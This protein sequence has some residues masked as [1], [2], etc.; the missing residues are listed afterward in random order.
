MKRIK[1]IDF[2]RGFAILAMLFFHSSYYWDS[3][4][5]REQMNQ[6]LS[7]PIAGLAILLGKAAGIFALISGMSYGVSTYNRISSGKSKPRDI[8]FSGLVT[9][10][11]VITLGKAHVSLFNH[12][13]IGVPEFPYPEGPPDYSLIIGSIQSGTLQLPTTFTV[14]Y[15]NSAL[16]VIGLSIIITS[17]AIA[18]LTLNDG[19]KKVKRNL[20]IIG[21]AAT[22]IILITQPMKNILYPLWFDAYIDGRRGKAI[23]LSVLIGDT[24]PFFPY[25]AYAL[26]GSIF[27]IAFSQNLDRKKVVIGGSVGGA[28]YLII[29]SILLGIYGH[30]DVGVIFQTLPIQWN[31]IMIGGMILIA[32]FAY[33]IHYRNEESKVRKF[34][35]NTFVRRYGLMTLSIFLFEPIIGI[36]L[37]VYVL[38]KVAPG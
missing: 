36:T 22:M 20:I 30:P 18:L 33:F 9:G 24:Y 15:K 23:L 12:T 31:F 19:Y 37:K 32:T 6:M 16:F 1:V 2:L 35:T 28:V 4:P 8:F 17:S 34:F 21:I 26:Y 7:N 38:D 10:L 11:W 5:S 13:Q 27:G 25:S 3:L 14:L 29:G